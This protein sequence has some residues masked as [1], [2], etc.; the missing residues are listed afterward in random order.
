MTE[1]RRKGKAAL[2]FCRANL[3]DRE[4]ILSNSSGASGPFRCSRQ[5]P[6]DFGLSGAEANSTLKSSH[7]TTTDLNE[8]GSTP[9]GTA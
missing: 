6:Q 3:P 4:A 1:T 5:S 7:H 9:A 8:V 2:R